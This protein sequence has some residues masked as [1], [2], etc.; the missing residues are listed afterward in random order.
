M[1]EKILNQ[2]QNFSKGMFVPVL[3]LPIAGI[4]IAI[5][6]ILTNAK[7]AM[8]LPFLKNPMIH[9][10]GKLL[11]GSLVSILVNLGI[12][13]CVGLAVGLSKK[14]KA[15]A[16]FTSLLVFLVFINA[17]N[18]FL[19][20]TNRLAPKDALRGTGQTMVLGVQVLDMGVFLGIILGIVVAY[21]HNRFC[22]KEFEGAFQIYGGS[23]LVFIILIPV[24]VLLA[25][26][27]SY[28]WPS[29]QYGISSL[30]NFI[31]GAGNFG[32]FMY[33]TLER[34]LIPTGLHHLVYTPFLYSPLGGVAEIGGKVF[35][36]ARNIYFAEMADP[37]ILKLSA[38]VIWDARGLSKMFGLIGACLAMYH[39]SLPEN[40]R[41]IKAIL[42]PAAVTSILAGVTEPIE[43]SFMFVAPILFFIHAVLSGLG[44]VVLNVLGIRAI[45]PNGFIDFLL[46]NLPLGIEKTGWPMF[47]LVGIGQFVVYYFV[48]RFL[49]TKFKLKTPGREKKGNTKLYTKKDYKEK[50][51]GNKKSENSNFA[52]II[53][54][55]L[56][57]K[58]NILKVDNCY[59]RL[60]LVLKDSS[61]VKE[62]LLKDETAANGVVIKGENVQ[63]IYGLKVTGIRK[64]V[65]EYL[66]IESN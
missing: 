51:Q 66:G 59:T 15:E 3:I 35:E 23:R 45:G 19:D 18:I 16:G 33:G 53:I 25:I 24:T 28:V 1:K 9:G 36:G 37:N 56:G 61:L 48:F 4:I 32:V 11:S 54:E 60:R 30:G 31:R 57:G 34:L 21:V 17:M 13:F 49:I 55:G 6:N 8:Y 44:M 39:T 62:E 29:V 22:E 40:K 41:K 65:D 63:V 58:D 2:L 42:I 47:I 12:I 52:P 5:G 7:L 14:K 46:Y 27:F 64:S 10:L 43:F 26:V 50:T 38:S 20:I